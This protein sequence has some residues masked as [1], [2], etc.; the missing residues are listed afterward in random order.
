MLLVQWH[1]GRKVIIHPE[2]ELRT[3][4]L[5]F[6]SGWRLLLASLRTLRMNRRDLPEESAGGDE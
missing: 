4:E 3:G 1:E 5:E 6:P 2:P